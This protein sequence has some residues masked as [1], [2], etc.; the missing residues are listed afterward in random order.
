[1]IIIN[2]GDGKGKSTA[3]VGAAIRAAGNGLK[4]KFIQFIKN[5]PSGELSILKQVGVDVL[6]C[7][8]GFTKSGEIAEHKAAAEAGISE[9][10]QAFN[11]NDMVICDEINY[12]V[13]GG[14]IEESAVLNLIEQAKVKNVHLILTGRGATQ[15]MIEAA[16]IVTMMTKI[17]HAYDRG[18]KSQI[19]IEY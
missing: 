2:D 8:A 14:L 12:A 1:M 4:V 3:A 18:I 15:Q 7:G 9:V 11:K 19:G 5:A 13:K 17:K 10:K 6:Q 16:D